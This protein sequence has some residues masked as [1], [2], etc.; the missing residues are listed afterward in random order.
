MTFLTDN[1]LDNGLN[2]LTTHGSRIDVCTQE[3]ANYTEATS[4]YTRGNKTGVSVGSPQNGDTSGRK[5]TVAAVT[6]GAITGNGT[7]THWALSKTTATAA[8][9]AANSLASSQ[10]VTSGNTFSLDA[11]DI[12]IPDAA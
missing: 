8:L 6:N 9:L 10:V 11:I 4:T 1:A 12:E 7:V 5:V 2:Y 3:P